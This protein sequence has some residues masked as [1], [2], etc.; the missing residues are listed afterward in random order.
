M[1]GAIQ[2]LKKLKRYVLIIGRLQSAT[3]LALRNLGTSLKN[4]RP[5]DGMYRIRF[6]FYCPFNY[7]IELQ[8]K[9]L[10]NNSKMAYE[11]CI[12]F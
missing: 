4:V 11:Y 10:L 12:S 6:F 3:K 1:Q 2:R 5:H 7:Q 8:T 9:N